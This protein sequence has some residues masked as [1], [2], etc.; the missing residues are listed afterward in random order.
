MIKYPVFL[1]ILF[2]LITSP[3]SFAEEQSNFSPEIQKKI[4][5]MQKYPPIYGTW[6]GKYFAKS[7]P[8]VEFEKN[9][10]VENDEFLENGVEIKLTISSSDVKLFLKYKPK[11]D[12]NEINGDIKINVDALGFQIIVYRDSSVWIERYWFSV[13]RTSEY[14]GKLVTTRSVHNWYGHESKDSEFFSI[15][16]EGVIRKLKDGI[17]K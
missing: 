2:I 11:D 12:W 3:V 16:S 7:M 13:A 1:I 4:D 17:E 14:G 5:E 6:V 15:Y 9:D 10:V 8:K